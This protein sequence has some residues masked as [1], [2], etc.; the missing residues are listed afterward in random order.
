MDKIKQN[1][2]GNFW[3]DNTGKIR[4]TS[5][6]NDTKQ[7]WWKTTPERR[8]EITPEIAQNYNESYGK[9]TGKIFPGQ[10]AYAYKNEILIKV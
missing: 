10:E 2:L 1:K 6:G 8:F 5:I 3:I 9:Y 7:R 4:I